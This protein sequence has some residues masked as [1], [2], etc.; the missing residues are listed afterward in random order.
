MTWA[1]V[2]GWVGQGGA[3]LGTKRTLPDKYFDQ[4]YYVENYLNHCTV[5]ETC[6]VHVLSLSI[7][8]S[9]K[10]FGMIKYCYICCPLSLTI[11]EIFIV[12]LILGVL[13]QNI[14]AVYWIMEVNQKK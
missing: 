13:L 14:I 11:E 8:K 3:F 5:T 1:E 7:T 10:C 2:T 9:W 12:M 6:L 4:V